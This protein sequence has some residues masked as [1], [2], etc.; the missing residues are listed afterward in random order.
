MFCSHALPLGSDIQVFPPFFFA[1]TGATQEY[2]HGKYEY[3]S[4]GPSKPSTC[5]TSVQGQA[6]GRTKRK[7]PVR[8]WIKI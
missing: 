6:Q 5:Q 4:P 3:I 7:V 8:K 1:L 2:D